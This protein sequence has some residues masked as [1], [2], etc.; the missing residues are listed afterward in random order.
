MFKKALVA[1]ALM[2][3]VSMNAANAADGSIIFTGNIIAQTCQ[4]NGNAPGDMPVNLGE[5]TSKE[6]NSAGSTVGNE[7]ITMALTACPTNVNAVSILFGGT[8]DTTNPELLANSSSGAT[9]VGIGIY[10]E[11][12]STAIPIN[13]ASANIPLTAGAG[14]GTFIA[15]YVSTAD[16]VGEGAVRATAQYTIQYK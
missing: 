3:A 5:Y 10:E 16:T 4:V 6:F 1:A 13:T 14:T 11:D 8:A 15:K 12:G 9:G 7:T 2:S